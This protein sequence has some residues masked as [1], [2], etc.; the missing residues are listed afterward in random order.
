MAAVKILVATFVNRDPQTVV[1][2]G[3][4]FDNLLVFHF[5]I[6]AFKESGD[7][8]PIVASIATRL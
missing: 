8:R 7:R 6:K 5:V 2:N 1:R 3:R 4:Q